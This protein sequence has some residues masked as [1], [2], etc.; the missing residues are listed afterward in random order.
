[1]AS[2]AVESC[3]ALSAHRVNSD[4]MHI[5]ADCRELYICNSCRIQK[6]NV[7]QASNILTKCF[8]KRF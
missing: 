7:C 1:M 2:G 4:M 8:S 5:L 3:V 6:P